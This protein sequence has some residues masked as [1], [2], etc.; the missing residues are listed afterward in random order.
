VRTVLNTW[1]NLFA[2]AREL[3][4]KFRKSALSERNTIHQ[5]YV[6]DIKDCKFSEKENEESPILRLEIDGKK[7][8]A[9]RNRTK[10][11]NAELIQAIFHPT[12][13]S[14]QTKL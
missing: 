6:F 9:H 11:S 5:E 12:I 7:F 2:A 1:V 3:Q 10:L 13:E 4:Q 14:I 8:F